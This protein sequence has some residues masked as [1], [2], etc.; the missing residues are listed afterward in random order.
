[1]NGLLSFWNRS[2]RGIRAYIALPT[3]RYVVI[4][5]AYLLLISIAETIT[6]L[7]EPQ[8]ALVLQQLI[9]VLGMVLYGLV[10]VL[11]LI[12][13]SLIHRGVLR[14]FL[15]VLSLAPL[16]RILSLSLPLRQW[17]LIYWYFAIG[18]LLFLAAFI[19][20]RVTDLGWNRIG[21][22]WR[23]WPLQLTF[24]LFGFGLGYVEY[25]ILQ[26]GPLAAY[27][28]WVDIILAALIL[29]IF[30]GVLE[31]YIF[32]GLMQSATMQMMGKFGLVYVAVL[33]AVLHLGYHSFSDVVFVLFVGLSFGW[34]V[35]KT[36]SLLGAS[37]AHGIANISLYVIFPMLISAGSFP[38]ASPGA[39]GLQNITPVPSAGLAQTAGITPVRTDITVDND[40]AGFVFVGSNLWL[41]TTH[42]FGGNFRWT[43]TSQTVPD[44]VVTWV[45]PFSGCGKYR[46]EAFIPSGIGLTES[47]RYSVDYRQGTATIVINQAAV[48]GTWA[49]LGVFEFEPGTSSN[50]RL[51]NGTGEDPK[52]LRWIGFDAV[53]WVFQGSC[54]SPMASPAR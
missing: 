2:I 12:H 30:T 6:T 44:L 46:V 25:L 13:G 11:L 17:P 8:L 53:R 9:L 40:D 27:R 38:V 7:V 48:Q 23:G 54:A 42:G 24:G 45:P 41:D 22:S 19:A 29:L 47:A 4:G 28:T 16:I 33:F 10:L 49:A 37:L 14:R 39:T 43:Y 1:M 51:S 3:G 36:H 35:W 20:G 50:I 15:I 18:M 21:W 34:W 52:L 32:R 31:E 26:P 5:L